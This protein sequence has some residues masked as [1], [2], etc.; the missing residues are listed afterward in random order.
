MPRLLLQGHTDSVTG[1]AFSPDGRMLAS[2]SLDDTIIVWDMESAGTAAEAGAPP[3]IAPVGPPLEGHVDAVTSIAFSPDG[4]LLASAGMDGSVLLWDMETGQPRDPPLQGHAFAVHSVAFSPDGKL[5]A[6]AGKDTTIILW[7]VKTSQPLGSPLEGHA[8][9]VHALAFSPDGRMLASRSID[10]GIM[11]WDVETRQGTSLYVPAGGPL[12]KE[13]LGSA[14]HLPMSLAFS[15]DSRMLA[16]GSSDGTLVLWDVA[17]SQPLG[18]FQAIS[19]AE[20]DSPV[21]VNAAFHPEGVLLA[22]TSFRMSQRSDAA[23]AT[24]TTTQGRV[25]VWDTSIA[26]WQER[27]CAIANRSLTRQEW[28]RFIGLELEYRRTCE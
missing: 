5:L 13:R 16:T 24:D 26:S 3:A 15:R 4:S 8:D 20:E 23:S 7:D 27:A 11:L 28:E 22:S 21:F 2:S 17:T 18:T 14:G 6:S 9:E 10:D 19:A 12:Q 1:V 25:M